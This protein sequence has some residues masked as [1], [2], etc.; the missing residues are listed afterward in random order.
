MTN[1]YADSFLIS[2]LRLTIL[3]PA[4]PW[5]LASWQ[6]QLLYSS[7]HKPRQESY[8]SIKHMVDLAAPKRSEH[9]FIHLSRKEG[10]KGHA[11]ANQNKPVLLPGFQI[12]RKRR[13]P[14]KKSENRQCNGTVLNYS[15]AHLDIH[16]VVETSIFQ[17]FFSD[18][19]RRPHED[20]IIEISDGVCA[21]D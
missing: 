18:L 7:G 10:R 3:L 15:S 2:L 17:A 4:G 9:M 8:A 19:V 1:S 13:R 16:W 5:F 12:Q 21:T 11:P 20:T 6:H 14:S